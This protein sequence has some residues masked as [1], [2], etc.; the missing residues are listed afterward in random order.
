MLLGLFDAAECF[1]ASCFNVGGESWQ[2]GDPV[3][4]LPDGA[5]VGA[6]QASAGDL[7]CCPGN[8]LDVHF[9]GGV[10]EVP[11]GDQLALSSGPPSVAMD[12]SS[13]CP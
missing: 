13:S 3:F 12:R 10:G 9:D 2:G 6:E 11:G 1:L 5:D 8:S 7:C 4:E